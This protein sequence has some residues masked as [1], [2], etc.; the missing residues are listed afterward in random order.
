MADSTQPDDHNQVSTVYLCGT[1]KQHVDWDAESVMCELCDTWYHLACQ[2]V[3]SSEYSK[4]GH[5]SVH[6]SCT[7]CNSD[8]QSTT[9]PA[10]LFDDS[11]H[12]TDIECTN[13]SA[14]V[15]IDDK[16]SSIHQSSLCKFKPPPAAR[17]T[18][19]DHKR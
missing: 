5:S 14:E 8:H 18:I 4:L 12:I 11:I 2:A 6:W 15:S 10:M 19:K 7:A 13:S 17:S 16:H 3:P 1:C 9:S